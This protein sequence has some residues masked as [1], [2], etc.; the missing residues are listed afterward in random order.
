M[1][2]PAIKLRLMCSNGGHILPRPHDKTLCYVGGETH[3][4]TMD[5][6]TTLS[7]LTNR[8]S[9]TL[10]KSSSS[11][12]PTTS[13]LI[14]Y[15]LPTEDLDS[16]I[17]I[18]NDE[19]LENMIDEYEKLDSGNNKRIRLFVFPTDPVSVSSNGSDLENFKSGDWFLNALNGTSSGFSDTSSSVNCLLGLDDEKKG[20][21]YRTAIDVN[22]METTSSS[23][24]SGTSIGQLKGVGIEEQFAQSVTSSA[25]VVVSSSP[26]SST[27]ANLENSDP[28]FFFH[29]RPEQSFLKQQQFQQKQSSGFDFA[30]PDSVLR[31]ISSRL[32]T[33]ILPNQKY[34]NTH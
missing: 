8:I 25:P 31:Y 34:R 19:D 10:I 12:C 5:R 26:V 28:F 15:Q 9:K 14:K 6:H 13:F 16:L 2:S 4:I 7:N 21:N 23:F 20:G 29:D 17:T 1:N 22:S 30:S 24:G 33:R 18:T 32:L 3:I 11:A 27:T